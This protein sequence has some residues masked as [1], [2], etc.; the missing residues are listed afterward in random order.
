MEASEI[1][2]SVDILEYIEQYCDDLKYENGEYWG[3]SPF[4]E[5]KTPSFS[6]NREKQKFYDFSSGQGGNIIEFIKLYHKCSVSE[7]MKILCD[8]AGI[9][10][11]NSFSNLPSILKIARRYKPIV[12]KLS[13]T[14]LQTLPD[15]YMDIYEPRNNHSL[16]WQKEGISE[17]VM[18]KFVVKYDPFSNYLVFPIRDYDGYIVNV[19][20]R[21]LDNNFKEK[22]LRK[23]T[24]F[25]KWNGDMNVLYGYSEHADSVREQKSII[26]FE[27]SKSVML[28]ETWGITNTAALLTSHLNEGQ[29]RFLIKLGHKVIFA[30]DKD[31]DIRNDKN[32][33]RLKRYVTVE[34]IKDTENILDEKMS[35]VDKGFGTWKHL[36]ERREKI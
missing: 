11:E 14:T 34:V 30:L 29:F 21:T 28:A 22:K 9:S 31:V 32:I 35:P 3:L 8:Y 26:I 12:S 17:Q 1:I 7:A 20:G 13:N 6:V 18:D 10:R 23:Y 16:M 15:T 36:Y 4:K 25:K 19:C 24:Y 27:G 2:S 33:A 5:E